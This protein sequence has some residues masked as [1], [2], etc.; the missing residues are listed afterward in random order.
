MLVSRR[1]YKVMLDHRLFLDRGPAVEAFGRDLHGCA[2]RLKGIECD[3]EF[4]EEKRREIAFLDT[5]DR[6]IALNRLVLRRRSELEGQ[7]EVEYTL[8]CRSPDRYV[9]AGADLAVAEGLKPKVK[10]EEDIGAPFVVRFSHSATVE[11]PD[12]APADL[13]SAAELFPTLGELERDGQ[14]C[15]GGL[16]LRPVGGL[17]AHERVVSGPTLTFHETEAEAALVL[18]SDGPAGRPLVAEFSFR[19]GRP[20]EDYSPRAAR[21][22]MTFFEEFQ[23]SDWC[24]ADGRTKTKFVYGEA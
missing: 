20:E 10:F 22:A 24:L 14:R 13:G 16:K 9:A 8:K 7:Q 5:S 15:P 11:G 18:W 3:G 2:K 12:E 4:R 17:R 1:E 19:Y 21:L 6:T 23:R